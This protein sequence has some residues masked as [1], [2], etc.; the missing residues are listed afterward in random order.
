MKI[1]APADAVEFV[2]EQDRGAAGLRLRERPPHALQHVAEIARLQPS[3]DRRRQ[4]GEL[5]RVAER[6]GKQGLAS[7]R[8]SRQQDLRTHFAPGQ[9]SRAPGWQVFKE[10]QRPFPSLAIAGKRLDS[11][12]RLAIK[13]S[14]IFPPARSRRCRNL[15]PGAVACSSSWGIQSTRR[16]RIYD[17]PSMPV[18]EGFRRP[19]PA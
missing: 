12:N 11:G 4:Q 2:D 3:R 13:N 6:L 7:A 14:R 5:Q 18:C 9:G 1:D 16:L 15:D 19:R 8:R 17:W 10:L